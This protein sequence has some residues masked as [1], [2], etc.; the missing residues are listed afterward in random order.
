MYVANEE[1]RDYQ[2]R[3]L[4]KRLSDN[5][6]RIV[7]NELE[8][9]MQLQ[10]TGNLELLNIIKDVTAH[11]LQVEFQEGKNLIYEG[12]SGSEVMPEASELSDNQGKENSE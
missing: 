7:D 10:N 11:C 3:Q 6:N 2:L 1:N 4:S 9:Q 5:I 8:S 12:I